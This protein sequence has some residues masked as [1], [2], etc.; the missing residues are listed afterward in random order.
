MLTCQRCLQPFTLAIESQF[1]LSPIKDYFEAEAL[2]TSYEPVMLTEGRW[3]EP[4]ALLAEELL[5][6][7]PH[8]PEHEMQCGDK[9]TLVNKEKQNQ[10]NSQQTTLASQHHAASQC[11]DDISKT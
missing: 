8:V 5:L 10:T 2:P 6:N 7:L 11:P 4:Y 3:L 9:K 1:S